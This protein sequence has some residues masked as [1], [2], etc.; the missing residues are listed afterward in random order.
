MN[1]RIVYL[2]TCFIFILT[3]TLNAQHIVWQ[4]TVDNTFLLDTQKLANALKHVSKETKTKIRI[5]F[6]NQHGILVDFIIEDN[7]VLPKELQKKF[8]LIHSYKGI[9]INNPELQLIFTCTETGITATL[10]HK[11]ETWHIKEGKNK[12][13][14]H[15]IT[16]KETIPTNPIFDC[17]AANHSD[18]KNDFKATIQ[19]KKKAAKIGDKQLRVL[20]T[21]IAV[22]DDYTRF[23]SS[24]AGVTNGSENQK[25]AAALGGI[26]ASLN[27]INVVYERD[28]GIR[29]EL[30]PNNDDIIFLNTQPDRFTT[31]SFDELSDLSDTVIDE[32]IGQ[33]NY[34]IGHLLTT[35]VLG[36]LARIGALC[37]NGK[38]VG[39][40]GFNKPEGDFFDITF[41]AHEL[42]HQFGAH[43]TQ[44]Y[45]CQ[46]DDATAVET[47]EG[48]TIMGYA[49]G[50]CDVP[51]VV[52][53]KSSDDYFHYVSIQ[54][55]KT[56]IEFG[57]SCIP[58]QPI[59]NK[60]PS[61]EP[62]KEFNIP[63]STAFA[64]EAIV[65]DR[66]EDRLTYTWEQID[67]DR[68]IAPPVSSSSVGP[69]FRSLPPNPSPR[70]DFPEKLGVSTKWE[71]LP[72]VP[73]A[74]NFGLTVRDG[75][76]G[77]VSFLKVTVNAI[78]TGAGIFEITSQNSNVSYDQ[79]SIQEVTWNVAGTTAN[80]IDVSDVKIE[81]SF[82]GGVTYPTI[83]AESTPNDGSENIRIPEGITT[84]QARI[85][86]SALKHIFY[87][88]NKSDFNIGDVVLPLVPEAR[89]SS[90]QRKKDNLLIFRIKTSEKVTDPVKIFYSFEAVPSN[91]VID[92]SGKVK[93]STDGGDSYQNVNEDFV[94]LPANSDELI[95]A[96][97][98]TNSSGINDPDK[99]K[100]VLNIPEGVSNPNL[101]SIGTL[102]KKQLD[103]KENIIVYPN[104]SNG[105]VT[106]E[107]L[108][109]PLNGYEAVIYN[110][111]GKPLFEY[112]FLTQIETLD[113]NSLSPGLYILSV[114]ING[115]NAI[116][117]IV[118][119]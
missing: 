99:I 45:P 31:K 72:S 41:F 14:Y 65:N 83:L 93:F 57:A 75:K 48:T 89:V 84:S 82:D 61:I 115:E 96:L 95:I 76:P 91:E 7:A 109:I 78:D 43:H 88:V 49:G 4:K 51:A 60:L 11:D 63:V 12:S 58:T 3:G 79:N 21:A 71:V 53:Q 26:V 5:S 111:E 54:E 6:P 52:I 15:V 74:M 47:G 17:K 29:L 50:P 107:I 25:K 113:L 36:G 56:Y 66:D 55:I 32:I 119:D 38:G 114:T 10:I 106:L 18:T 100:L 2:F 28:L 67:N 69:L 102:A 20:R 85:R 68:A 13:E 9:S 105:K 116:R 24:K 62:L 34:D 103:I 110:L 16:S 39:V 42:G 73:R 101:T 90:R 44:N 23:F 87:A 46:R 86:V 8:P 118:I 64:L 1:L 70:R 94:T 77:G 27:R 81:I 97:P 22:T 35:H 30:I 40:T 92:F 80:G 98:L 112:S 33:D 19:Q 117:K 104:P 37:G 59:T 108:T